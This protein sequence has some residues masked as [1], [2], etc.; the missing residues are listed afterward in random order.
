MVLNRN[1]E[2]QIFFS[3]GFRGSGLPVLSGGDQG[4][5]ADRRRPVRPQEVAQPRQDGHVQLPQL[6][7]HRRRRSGIR[8]IER[9]ALHEQLFRMNVP[10]LHCLV[11][12]SRGFV[13]NGAVHD[14]FFEIFVV[15]CQAGFAQCRFEKLG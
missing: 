6:G 3:L 15:A 11:A 9:S 10:P 4:H 1:L 8:G 13:R 14:C 5:G 12:A 2:G 7:Q